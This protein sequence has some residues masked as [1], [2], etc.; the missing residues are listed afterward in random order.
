ML[1]KFRKKIIAIVLLVLTMLSNLLP[2]FP[3]VKSLAVNNNDIGTTLDIV[4]LGTI[5]Y[6]LK[7]YGVPSKGY[8]I[9]QTVGYYDNGTLYAQRQ[10]RCR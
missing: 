1:K 7:S 2:I 9:T 3:M 8:I 5:P 6:H 4:N 10:T